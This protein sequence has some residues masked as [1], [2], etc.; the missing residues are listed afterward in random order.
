M[1]VLHSYWRSSCSYRVRIA[2]AF[3]GIPYE[4]RAVNL[5]AGEQLT[6]AYRAVNP[7]AELPAL[8]ID[9]AVLT[10]STAIV[11]Y[12]EETRP[13]PALLPADPVA[14]AHV[15]AVCSLISNDMQPV[16]NLR[17]LKRVAGLFEDAATGAAARDAWAKAVVSS[18]LEGLEA[19]LR[20]TA[21][22]RCVGDDVSLADAYLVPQIYNAVRFK[23]DLGPYPTVVRVHDALVQLPAFMSAHPSAQPD[24]DKA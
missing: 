24:A 20:R 15:R 16:Q 5:L 23:I 4:Y 7:M 18:G 12:L 2:L 21:G 14:R 3:K 19:L 8:E 6:D 9:G 17:V 11:E 1:A 13:S 22:S 10:Q